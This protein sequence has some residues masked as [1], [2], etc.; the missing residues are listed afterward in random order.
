M[1]VWLLTRWYRRTS[2]ATNHKGMRLPR[3]GAR[4]GAGVCD[5]VAKPQLLVDAGAIAVIDGHDGMG[6]VLTARAVDKQG[7]TVDFLLTAHR[8]V[9]AARCFVER[10]I[11]PNGLPKS[12][13]I[14]K[15]QLACPAA[16]AARSR[17]TSGSESKR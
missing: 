7:Q 8:D 2:G 11:S 3:H 4:L 15:S 16:Y 6:Q 1:R 14:D 17:A 10:A 13:T 5:P 12:M 9:A